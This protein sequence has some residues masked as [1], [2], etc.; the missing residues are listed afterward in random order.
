VI[1]AFFANY[2]FASNLLLTGLLLSFLFYSIG[3]SISVNIENHFDKSKYILIVVL[4][5][6]SLSKYNNVQTI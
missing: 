1:I 5:D 3:G 4:A 2:R 6:G